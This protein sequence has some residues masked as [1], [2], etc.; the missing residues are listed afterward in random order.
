MVTP[1]KKLENENLFTKKGERDDYVIQL[2]FLFYQII[3]VA[4]QL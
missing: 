4:D 3:M 2:S 1:E